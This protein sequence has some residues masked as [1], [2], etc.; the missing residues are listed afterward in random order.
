MF[1]LILIFVY[2]L[3][4]Q[5]LNIDGSEYNNIEVNGEPREF[6]LYYPK[7]LRD[8]EKS[9]QIS[10][11]LWV[12]L[13][14]QSYNAKPFFDQIDFHLVAEDNQFVVVFAQGHCIQEAMCCWNTGH[15]RGL[16]EKDWSKDDIKYIEKMLE[17]IV[18]TKVV[19]NVKID[20]DEIVITGFSAGAF[21]THTLATNMTKYAPFAILP[22]AGHA[23]GE[24]AFWQPPVRNY[25]PNN[26]GVSSKTTPHMIAVYGLEDEG[27]PIDGGYIYGRTD[28]SKKQDIDLWISLNG[29]SKIEIR[30]V[31]YDANDMLELTI[32][33]IC[34][35]K[36]MSLVAKK[37][38]HRWSSYT[39]TL[40][41]N[42]TTSFARYSKTFAELLYNLVKY[43]IKHV[44]IPQSDPSPDPPTDN[45]GIWPFVY[46]C[47]GCS[48][49]FSVGFLIIIFVIFI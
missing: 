6:L 34:N 44:P 43:E 37:A 17:I 27:V 48:I 24:S 38:N 23:G 45:C 40:V 31:K 13:H 36:V 20:K 28:F 22:V 4:F 35:K 46:T 21:M 39:K 47:A 16:L 18:T 12:V 41:D 29:C 15:L 32:Y 11:P 1:L 5:C 14:G 25:D 30:D 42:P 26:F 33:A 8:R 9:S 49:H 7:S 2:I 10:V 3:S 19:E